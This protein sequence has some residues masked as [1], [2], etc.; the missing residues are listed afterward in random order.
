MGQRSGTRRRPRASR[1][2]RT[3]GSLR[4][5]SSRRRRCTNAVG[6]APAAL[7][8]DA[9]PLSP[10]RAAADLGSARPDGALVVADPGPAGL[11]VARALPTTEL[12]ERRRARRCPCGASPSPAAIAASFEGRPA[13]AVRD[14]AR[15]PSHGRVVR[16][17]R[18]LGCRRHPRGLGRR[19]RP[20]RR[21]R[22]GRAPAWG[23]RRPASRCCHCR[24]ISRDRRC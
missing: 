19:R 13:V 15:R 23:A 24:S 8:S 4:Y 21:P 18:A 3:N 9:V 11:W 2:S 16:A 20:A 22:P 14:R 12:G 17:G 6:R 10:A 7:R 1:R 5:A